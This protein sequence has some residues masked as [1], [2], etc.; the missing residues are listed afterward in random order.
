M[1]QFYLKLGAC[2]NLTEK[3]K[4]KLQLKGENEREKISMVMTS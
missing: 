3:T 4:E 2:N 1:R